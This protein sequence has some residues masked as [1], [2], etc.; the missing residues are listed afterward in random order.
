M[1][2]DW[3]NGGPG[4]L[5]LATPMMQGVQQGSEMAY[6]KGELQNQAAQEAD[7]R[8]RLGIEQQ[9]QDL[10]KAQFQAGAAMRGVQLQLAQTGLNSATLLAQNVADDH[11]TLAT[12][13]ADMNE[14]FGKDPTSIVNITPPA[15][16]TPQALQEWATQKAA[17]ADTGSG[18]MAVN[19]A[20]NMKLAQTKMATQ[21]ADTATEALQLGIDPGRYQLDDGS[22]DYQSL[23]NAVNQKKIEMGNTE[24]ATQEKIKNAGQIA[25]VNAT[26]EGREKVATIMTGGRIANAQAGDYTKQLNTLQNDLTKLQTSPLPDKQ[27][28]QEK[29]AAIAD[30]MMSMP[31]ATAAAVPSS[32]ASGAPVAPAG[33]SKGSSF[34]NS[35][36]SSPG[37]Q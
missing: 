12:S 35:L 10:Q 4:Q 15:F 34:I 6:R 19:S 1:A 28:I 30:L 32:S 13:L 5:D 16:K 7:M 22:P 25:V 31:G 26:Q 20:A 2:F 29:K 3:M 14:Q 24:L 23:A 8:T 21:N 17:L 9:S 11:D 18:A 37:G 27:A 36:F 33:P